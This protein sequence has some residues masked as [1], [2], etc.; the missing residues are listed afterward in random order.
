MS[1]L[2]TAN[3]YRFQEEKLSKIF[4]ILLA[5]S[6][7]GLAVSGL[8]SPWV[9]YLA[10]AAIV[11]VAPW[12]GRWLGDTVDP[13]AASAEA[14]RKEK[15]AK[16]A[17]QKFIAQ[18]REAIG[19]QYFRATFLLAGHIAAADGVVCEGEQQQLDDRFLK[20]QLD[21][22]Q[23]QAAIQYFNEGQHPQFNV[24]EA[25]DVFVEYCGDIP[26]LCES[27]LTTQCAFADASGEVVAAE[28]RVIEHIAKRLG[29]HKQ[30]DS[31]LTEFKL[32]A[33]A[34]AEKVAEERMQARQRQRDKKRSEAE[35]ARIDKKISAKARTVLL[36]LAV[37]GL[38]KQASITEIKRAY[39]A[40]IKRHHPDR[41]LANGYPEELLSEATQR[42][43]EINKAYKTL[44]QHYNFR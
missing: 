25:L 7:I 2:F 30:F 15:S 4:T 19:F 38:P 33:Q 17:R 16:K 20:L 32:K 13:R 41:L 10:G 22:A 12:L 1:L 11:V 14:Y 18:N 31:L 8:L 6:G 26:A 35:K 36:A 43:A 34:H 5:V 27:L 21:S 37:L 44:K 23:V 28:F 29:L 24:G 39:R 3:S 9:S 40:H 42:S